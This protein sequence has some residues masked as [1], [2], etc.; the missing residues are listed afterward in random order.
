MA[1]I[2]KIREK[3]WLL[4]VV[5]G[6]ALIA[7]ILPELTKGSTPDFGP[8]SVDGEKV[9]PELYNQRM[10]EVGMMD[11]QQAN[12]QQRPYTAQDQ[13]NSQDKAWGSLVEDMMFDKEY[14][15]LGIDVSQRE[16]DAY[17]YGTD[18]FTVMPD[19]AQ[20]FSDSTGK[21]NARLLEQRIKQMEES[22]DPNEVAQ[23]EQNKRDLRKQ[24]KT[25]KYF[26]LIAQGVYVTDL[27]AQDE[28]NAQ[29][30][31]KSVSYIVKRYSEIPDE[32][33]KV[34]D[35]AVK[36]YY[37]AHK[38]EKKWEGKAART[39]KYFE[40]AIA[41]SKEDI[42][43]FDT[44]LEKIKTQFQTT[45]NDSLFVLANSDLKAFSSTHDATFR[46]EGDPKARQGMTYPASMDSVFKRAAI[47]DIV[48]PYADQ[49]VMRLAKVLDFN[50]YS[51]KARH[52][53]ISAQEGDTA[54]FVKAQRKADSILVT[55][56]K[57]NFE[58][59]VTLF[60]EDPGSKDKGGVYEDFLDYEMVPEFS[61]FIVDKPVG[62]I[63]SVKTNFG[64]H[65]IEVMDK[66][67][68]NFPVLALVQKT[69]VPSQTTLD[70]AQNESYD[71]L[72]MME[73]SISKVKG[74]KAKLEKF[75]ELAR[76]K[77][78][79]VTQ[80]ILIM[81]ESPKVSAFQ[82]PMAKDKILKLAY[83]RGA[84]VGMLCSSPI[85]DGD[86]Y[87]IAIIESISKKGTP[88]FDNVSDR[89]KAEV[90]KELKAERL[91]KMLL[92]SKTIEAAA[93]KANTTAADAEITFANP[94]FPGSGY[95]PAV[96]GALFS[97]LKDGQMTLPLV[98]EQGVY[99][100]R[101]NKTAKAPVADNYNVEKQQML[102]ALRGNVQNAIRQAMYEKSNVIDNRK[103]NSLGL[104]VD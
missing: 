29:K 11:E 44:D 25:D 49:G 88:D 43:K 65:I 45:K 34:S 99:L 19:L 100:V 103:F 84:E 70:D 17:L 15:A 63:G 54:S 53:L 91:T 86:K 46:P 98:G 7:F 77:N 89:M 74:N 56:N 83:D 75:E 5:V 14:E 4:I 2:G 52:I 71:M 68:V 1:L 87:I 57:N 55:L 92:G 12:Q 90:M 42:Q 85:K 23:W 69:L 94:Q 104:T 60:T 81:S 41:P 80:P 10:M 64:I 35:D 76:K 39:V 21:F 66:K 3:S 95:E 47:G 8:G 30:E 36:K 24:R 51:L 97:G 9:N 16:A 101:L 33:I 82:T 38:N 59:Y 48:G 93:Q 79:F 72:E 67:V 26:Q 37:E 28:Y 40:I 58:E 78:Y 31:I 62:T 27:E 6:I 61:K 13:E 20:S 73:S 96:V 50:K 102:S 18:G 22:S 32:D